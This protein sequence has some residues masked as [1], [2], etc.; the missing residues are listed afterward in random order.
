MEPVPE[1]S[2]RAKSHSVSTDTV[3]P[4]RGRRS[5]SEK[6]ESSRK[7]TARGNKRAQPQPAVIEESEPEEEDIKPNVQQDVRV[8]KMPI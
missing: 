6:P 4:P 1:V 3:Q 5:Q 8:K 2:E 7:A